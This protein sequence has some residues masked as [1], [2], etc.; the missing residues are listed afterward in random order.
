MRNNQPLV[1]LLLA[2]CLAHY[3]NS[4][5]LFEFD[6]EEVKKTDSKLYLSTIA[7]VEK[8]RNDLDKLQNYLLPRTKILAV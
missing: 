6:L 7:F 5:K 4:I 2:C 3:Q 8:L 1:L